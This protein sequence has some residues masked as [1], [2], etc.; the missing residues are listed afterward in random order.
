MEEH[1]HNEVVVESRYPRLSWGAIFAGMVVVLSLSWLF[2]FLGL[3]MGVSLADAY[4]SSTIEGALD[5][6]AAVWM[7]VSWLLAF[8]IGSLVAARLAGPIDDFAGMLHGLTLWGLST[9][10]MAVLTYYSVS[11]LIGVGQSVIT[12]TASG[13]ATAGTTAGAAVG[14]VVYGVGSMTNQVLQSELADNVQSRLIDRS[15]EIAASADAE[16]SEQDIRRAINGLD[17]RTVRRIVNDLTNKDTDGAAELLAN[18]TQISTENANDIVEAVYEELEEA[19]GN[20]DNN[21]P[22]T[23]DVKSQIIKR[24]DDYLASLDAQG[25]PQ[26]TPKDVRQAIRDLDAESVESIALELA[27]GDV[28]GAKRVVVRRTDLSKAQIDDLFEGITPDIDVYIEEY[29]T[30]LNEWSE[31]VVDY[32]Q[33]ILWVTF[34]GLAISLVVALGGGWLGATSSH[35]AYGNHVVRS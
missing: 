35:E 7:V 25:G 30:A 4:D 16:V 18:A 28:D 14:D 32:T 34:G 6:G 27:G 3:A 21:Q 23:A 33:S 8:F 19:I 24:A 15:I 2:Q 11:T 31:D 26:V 29:T 13:V 20:P 22:L 12:T 1:V 10:I 9:L 17:D 5:E